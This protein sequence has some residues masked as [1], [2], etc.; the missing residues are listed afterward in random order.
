[1]YE[2]FL[3]GN[4]DGFVDY[5]HPKVVALMGGRPKVIE[6]VRKMLANAKAQGLV[7]SAATVGEARQV[8]KSGEMAVQV[9]LP[10]EIVFSA[11]AGELHQPSYL[12]G[13]SEDDGKNWKFTDTGQS[14]AEAF[15]KLFP[16]CSP[17]LKIPP[18]PKSQ[19][20][21][22]SE[23]AAQPGVEPVRGLTP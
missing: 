22:K 13:L 4:Y 20:V 15:R 6:A 17:A 10:T 12:L 14:S 2:A 1:M 8:T 5:T 7:L 21:P 18:R 9:I 19:F 11:A 16:E 23:R 3:R